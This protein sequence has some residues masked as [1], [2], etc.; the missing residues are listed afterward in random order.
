MKAFCVPT[1]CLIGAIPAALLLFHDK[2]T[3]VTYR[4]GGIL[5]ERWVKEGLLVMMS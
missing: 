3:W 5:S 1:S 4:E 2:Y